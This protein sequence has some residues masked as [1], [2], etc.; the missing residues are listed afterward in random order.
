[1]LQIMAFVLGRSRACEGCWNLQQ[2]VELDHQAVRGYLEA[3]LRL[4]KILQVGVIKAS[5]FVD[6]E[7][8]RSL[9]WKK[10][11]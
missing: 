11:S 7:N 2:L 10:E 1:M 4:P 3:F 8:I 5:G 6:T 9:L